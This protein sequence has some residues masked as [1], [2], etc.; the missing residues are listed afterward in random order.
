MDALVDTDLSD[1]TCGWGPGSANHYAVDAQTFAHDFQADYLKVD[2]CGAWSGNVSGRTLPESCGAGALGAGGDLHHANTTVANA[3][4][5]C[6]ASAECGG[7]TTDAPH[8][9]ACDESNTTVRKIYFKVSCHDIAA[10]WVAFFSRCQR[11]LLTGA[12]GVEH[13]Q[14]GGIQRLV[15]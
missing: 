4:A 2:F 12:A 8:A 11:S 7:F 3:T 6:L 14:R 5:W 15:F 9:S 1:H 13:E 10:I